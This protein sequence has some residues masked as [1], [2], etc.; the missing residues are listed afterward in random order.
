MKPT[1]EE[2]LC[3]IADH[4]NHEINDKRN[5][6]ELLSDIADKA[7]KLFLLANDKITDEEKK[8]LLDIRSIRYYKREIE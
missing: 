4:D 6:D 3:E 7:E 8:V 1:L 2:L 5:I